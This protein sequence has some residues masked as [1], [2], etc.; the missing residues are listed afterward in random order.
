LQ[1]KRTPL[2]ICWFHGSVMV[3]ADSLHH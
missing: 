2:Q 3:W 1:E